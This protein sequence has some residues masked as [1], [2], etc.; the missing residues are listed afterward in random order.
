[1]NSTWA[2]GVIAWIVQRAANSAPADICHRLEEEWLADLATYAD[3]VLRLRFALGCFW[4][5]VAL[6]GDGFAASSTPT[7]TLRTIAGD[8]QT[9]WRRPANGSPFTRR[10]DRMRQEALAWLDWLKRRSHHV[11]TTRTTA[12]SDNAQALAV[13]GDT[14][15]VK[16]EWVA[17]RPRRSPLINAGAALIA[18]FIS[19][20]PLVYTHRY[21]PD[22]LL[23]P[24]EG[25][26]I[27]TMGTVYA[28]DPQTLRRVGIEDGTRIAMNRRARI[29]VLYSEH[30]RSA[31]LEQ[32]EATFTVARDARR[33]FDLT[34]GGRRF[35]T[36]AATFDVRLTG[37]ASMEVT[38]LDGIVH[39]LPTHTGVT[40]D[41]GVQAEGA[42]RYPAP[43][44]LKPAQTIDIEPGK[45]SVH[46]LSELEAQTRVAWNR[47]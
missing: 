19:A 21:V 31:L 12:E 4:A 14:F 10:R 45:E 47:G 3:P 38:V 8:A 36:L 34:V 26:L 17:A 27:D 35:S 22:L 1:M 5:A 25:S 30:L 32:G 15:Q 24:R 41:S 13:L 9:P 39:L 2:G 42:V 44:L 7:P 37:R 28:S 40:V 6:R 46:I 33:P 29:A 16:P 20:L 23:G 11:C 43:T 18:L